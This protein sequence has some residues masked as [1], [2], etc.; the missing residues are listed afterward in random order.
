M[1]KHFS[2]VFIASTS[3]ALVVIMICSPSIEADEAPVTQG[4]KLSLLDCQK[5]VNLITKKVIKLFHT[6]SKEVRQNSTKQEF[7]K[8]TSC[9]I[10][11]VLDNVG[12]LT[13]EGTCTP[14][15][16]QSFLNIHIPDEAHDFAHWA[17]EHCVT[18]YGS[19]LDKSQEFCESYGEFVKCLLKLFADFQAFSEAANC[20]FKTNPMGR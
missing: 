7:E 10:R 11:C 9:I 12:L 8:K 5:I 19:K 18:D 1:V 4:S 3:L 2:I 14:D 6:C 20:K 13:E 16:V 17:T 15:T